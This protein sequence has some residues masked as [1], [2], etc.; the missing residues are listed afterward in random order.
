MS[1][2][3]AFALDFGSMQVPGL[4]RGGREPWGSAS[5][6]GNLPQEEAGSLQILPGC[7]GQGGQLRDS[8]TAGAA[9]M[10]QLPI[11]GT[12]GTGYC[13]AGAP[14]FTQHPVACFPVPLCWGTAGD[15]SPP[16]SSALPCTPRPMPT[17]RRLGRRSA[18]QSAWPVIF[19][20]ILG[21]T[22]GSQCL[23]LAEVP[24]SR[25]S[26]TPS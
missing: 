9:P 5:R 6:H 8:V 12:E 2:S 26:A 3:K 11:T 20:M 19:E 10:N 23:P 24:V 25:F 22:F 15:H 14:G 21:R 13:W 4:S 7:L 18:G 1:I 16:R 17:L